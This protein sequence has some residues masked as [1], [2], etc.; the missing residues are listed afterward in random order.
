MN[1]RTATV[2]A[3]AALVTCLAV[4]AT[5]TTFSGAAS[6]PCNGKDY[7]ADH[8]GFCES[9]RRSVAYRS[10]H[11]HRLHLAK[12]AQ[13]HRARDVFP[14]YASDDRLAFQTPAVTI[15]PDHQSSNDENRK[16]GTRFIV[17]RTVANMDQDG[18]YRVEAMAPWPTSLNDYVRTV[19]I[20]HPR[21]SAVRSSH[22]VA[23]P[24]AKTVAAVKPRAVPPAQSVN[25]T[26]NFH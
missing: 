18:G 9:A 24:P 22:A 7:Y 8:Q 2:T 23:A 3:L 25:L 15:E 19:T 13:R 4:S 21:A 26:F 1:V 6:D 20:E 10:H 14:S 5:M 17:T 12:V 11:R 16:D